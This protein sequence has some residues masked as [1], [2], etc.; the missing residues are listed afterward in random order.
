MTEANRHQQL[1][2]I[3]TRKLG[4]LLTDARLASR[5]SIEECAAVMGVSVEQYKQ[6]ENGQAAPTL[7]ECEALAYHLNVNLEHFWGSQALSPKASQNEP[8]NWNERLRPLRDKMI[9]AKLRALRNKQNISL[10]ELAEATGLNEQD[11]KQYEFGSKTLPL[12]ALEILATTLN[13]RIEEFF[14]QHGPIGKWRDQNETL[15]KF[16][17]LPD[18]LQSFVCVPVN[19]PYLEL[20]MRLSELNVEKL[21][22]VAESLLEITY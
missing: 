21:R 12:P 17:E 22:K 16:S 11:L 19:R 7:P 9:G 15:Q 6:Y 8:S 18:E 20:A 2:K 14:D 13:T 3:R 5:H 4:I 1:M 10:P